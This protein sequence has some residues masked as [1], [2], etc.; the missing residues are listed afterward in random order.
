MARHCE[1][2][3]I[4]RA[5]RIAQEVPLAVEATNTSAIPAP[6]TSSHVTLTSGSTIPRNL[7]PRPSTSHDATSAEATTLTAPLCNLDLDNSTPENSAPT[8]AAPSGKTPKSKKITEISRE[9]IVSDLLEKK[10]TPND[11]NFL[12]SLHLELCQ[13]FGM[14]PVDS[15]F[16]DQLLKSCEKF[17]SEAAKLWNK[18]NRVEQRVFANNR[19]V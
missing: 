15:P 10:I 6:G 18:R 12:A 5:K 3:Q 8:P 9:K 17:S 13:D 1:R 2:K 14:D 11:D 19:G 16:S 7:K 4:A